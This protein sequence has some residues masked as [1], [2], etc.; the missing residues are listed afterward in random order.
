VWRVSSGARFI[1]RTAQHISP[2]WSNLRYIRSLH[3]IGI[4]DFVT[5]L[6]SMCRKSTGRMSLAHSGGLQ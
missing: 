5:D 2:P 4:I 6:F 1:A 3:T